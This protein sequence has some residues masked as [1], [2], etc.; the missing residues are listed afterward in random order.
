ML[1]I[2]NSWACRFAV[3]AFHSHIRQLGLIFFTL[4]LSSARL[5]ILLITRLRLGTGAAALPLVTALPAFLIACWDSR[6]WEDL[7]KELVRKTGGGRVHNSSVKVKK[8]SQFFLFRFSF[9]KCLIRICCRQTC[10]RTYD[11]TWGPV[12]EYENA[13]RQ[14]KR[15]I[16]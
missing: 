2:L 9:Y 15:N 1:R 6:Q 11:T 4:Q 8:R 3:L 5:W 12:S 7:G 14:R 16:V 13:S 10:D